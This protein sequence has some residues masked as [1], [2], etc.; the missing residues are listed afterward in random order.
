MDAKNLLIIIGII[1]AVIGIAV[2]YIREL[3]KNPDDIEYE[4]IYSLDYL[5]KGVAQVFA[6]TQKTN[7]RE[8]NLSKR[9]LEAEKRKKLELKRNL[10][11]AAYGDSSAKKYIKSLIQEILQ[12]KRFNIN[13]ETISLVIPFHRE[14]ALDTRNKTD[15]ILYLYQKKYGADGFKHLMKDFEL[16]K[17]K[18]NVDETAGDLLYEITKQDIDRVYKELIRKTRLSFSDKIAIVTQRI[19]ADF[20]GFGV[21]DLLTEFAVDEIDCGVSG[22]PQGSYDTK[23]N[24]ASNHFE[25]SYE[26][27]WVV[28][29]GI[30]YKLSCMSFGS[31]E[32]FVRVCQNI[33]KYAAPYAL[34]KTKGKIVGTM[35]DGS[36]ISVSR[37]PASAGWSFYLRKFDSVS[38]ASPYDLVTDEGREIP[39]CIAKWLTRAAQSTGITGVM[40]AGKTTWLRTQLG[41]S[42]S[43]KSIRVYELAYELNLQSCF[44]KRNIVAMAVTESIGMQELYDFGKKTNANISVISECATSEMGVIVVHSATVGSEAAYFTH[45]ANTASGLVLSL[46]DNLTTVGGYSDERV[47]EEVVA[48][49]IHFNIHWNRDEKGKRYIQRITEIIPNSDVRYPSEKNAQN[50]GTEDTLEYYKRSTNPQCFTCKNIVEFVNGRYVM[51]NPFSEERLLDIRN[52]LSEEDEKLFMADYNLLLK[53]M[54]NRERVKNE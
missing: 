43:Q 29:A 51:A 47:A 9:E 54:D 6:D 36:R 50:F 48:K 1:A 40:G 37:Y 14:S 25:Y 27:I 39:I 2:F 18:N 22:I 52:H 20:K 41:F 46:R 33:Y 49:A 38:S 26:S 30:N 10:K 5:T 45:H 3:K 28:F 11:T 7:L 16:Y 12:S 35:K 15:I 21:V 42:S 34:S 8:Q 17:P 44:P 31:Q 32:E 4:S 19:F 24:I 13:E 23:N 53:T